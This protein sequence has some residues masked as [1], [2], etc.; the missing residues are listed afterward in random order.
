MWTNMKIMVIK[1]VISVSCILILVPIFSA[2]QPEE[3]L[4]LKCAKEV[5]FGSCWDYC[6]YMQ[7]NRWPHC[8]DIARCRYC[9][10]QNNIR[11]C[12]PVSR[13]L[14]FETMKNFKKEFQDEYLCKEKGFKF[15]YPTTKCLYHYYTAWFYVLPLGVFTVLSTA[16][17]FVVQKR[18]R[19]AGYNSF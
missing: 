16:V 14:W 4:D 10:E 8:C 6:Y 5:M 11:S 15:E 13:K 2:T 9:A 17:Y 18:R 7:I 19:R 12:G 1:Q 3:E